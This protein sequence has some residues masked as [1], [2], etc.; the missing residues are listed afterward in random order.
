MTI[1]TIKIDE[2]L[3]ALAIGRAIIATRQ[4]EATRLVGGQRLAEVLRP[5]PGD[6]RPGG[7][8]VDGMTTA[9]LRPWI[10]EHW[11]G[12]QAKLDAGTCLP[13]PVRRVIFP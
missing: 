2:D 9:D 13:A 6:H 10:W 3:M 5:R 1:M 4:P 8:G 7:H 11:A 12:L